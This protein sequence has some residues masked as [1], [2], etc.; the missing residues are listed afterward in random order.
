MIKAQFI[1]EHRWQ[2][3]SAFSCFLFGLAFTLN[4]HPIGDGLW[5]WYATLMRGGQRLYADM[6]LPLQ[7]VFVL[8]TVWTQ[9]VFGRGWLASKILAAAQLFSY[10]V[11]L[12]LINRLLN[13]KDWQKAILTTSVFGMTLGAF[14]FRFDDYHIT[15]YCLE[16]FSIYALLRLTADSAL[17]TAAILGVLSGL[18]LSNR[19][20]DGA[21]LFGACGLALLFFVPRRR[22]AAALTFCSTTLLTILV[23]VAL[24]GDSIRNWATYSIFRAAAIKGGTGSVLK[25]PLV[26]PRRMFTEVHHSAMIQHCLLAICLLAAFFITVRHYG[27]R[28]DG[29]LWTWRVLVGSAVVLLA[30]VFAYHHLIYG[31]PLEAIA[32]LIVP[33]SLLLIGWMLFR[34]GRVLFVRPPK[35]WSPRE[36]LLLVPFL[37]IMAG[38]MTSGKS[39]L[40]VYP[41]AAMLLLILPFSLPPRVWGWSQRAFF[42]GVAVAI[43]SS[44][45]LTKTLHPYNWHHFRDGPLFVDRQWYRHPLYGP[46]YIESD[47]LKLVQSMCETISKDG[48]PTELLSITNPYPN[49][50]CGV[51]PWHGYVQTW[52]DTTSQQTIDALIGEL[53]AAPPKWII[54]Q[55]ATDSMAAHESVFMGDVVYLTALL[56]A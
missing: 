33:T 43:T 20:N 49:Y 38:A 23:V 26:F 10:C 14:Y 22:L 31:E 39:I 40:E 45:L 56:I 52:Y 19:L 42:V 24:T 6:H 16:A 7:P 11:A 21:G 13:W 53:K 2:L 34:L 1:R 54:Y 41:A 25:A 37:Q 12:F 51:P 5:F 36:L 46:M 30:I 18:S 47:Q 35:G 17:P 32:T 44:A 4:I 3:L 27:K 50:F 8:L 28:P 29:R 55:R 15:G 48:P 9:K